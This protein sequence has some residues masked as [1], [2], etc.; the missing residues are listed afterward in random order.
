MQSIPEEASD[1]LAE[2][3]RLATELDSV[4]KEL[5]LY[6]S[7]ISTVTLLG[8]Y[9]TYGP[10]LTKALER[11]D[12]AYSE[13]TRRLFWH[14]IPHNETLQVIAAYL[15]RRTFAG[16]LFMAMATIPSAITLYLLWLQNGKIDQQI[17]LTA[18]SQAAQLQGSL[19]ESLA[20]LYAHPKQLCLIETPSVKRA[21][22]LYFKDDG[23]IEKNRCWNEVRKKDNSITNNWLMLFYRSGEPFELLTSLPDPIKITKEN[24]GLHEDE[25]SFNSLQP[26]DDLLAKVTSLS[27]ALRPYRALVDNENI[28]RPNVTPVISGSAVSPERAMLMKAFVD[29]RLSPSK[30]NFSKAWAPDLDLAGITWEGVD[31]S[32]AMLECSELQGNYKNVNFAQARAAGASF[33]RSDL[34]GVKTLDGAD[35]RYAMFNGAVLPIPEVFSRANIERAD[36]DEAIVPTTDWLRLVVGDRKLEIEKYNYEPVMFEETPKDRPE[37]KYWRM[38]AAKSR[39]SMQSMVSDAAKIFCSERRVKNF[40]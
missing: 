14:R 17:Y 12:Q 31:L 1:L 24:G 18:S 40:Q 33:H 21:A 39:S 8:S 30:L 2:N 35:F 10:S 19:A 6:R 9:V 20:D 13:S 29:S 15:R 32:G 3:R 23:G 26:M 16:L 11:W 4:R 28:D 36:F 38:R 27:N 37:R 34:R 22:K 5:H 7:G 25:F